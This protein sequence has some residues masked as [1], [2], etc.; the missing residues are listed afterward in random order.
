M[1]WSEVKYALNSSLGTEA[2][3]SLDKLIPYYI[4]YQSGINVQEF[5][6]PGSYTVNV[7]KWANSVKVTACGGG[8]GGGGAS[9]SNSSNGGGG[10]G[11]GAAI[12]EQLFNIPDDLITLNITVGKGGNGRRSG[13]YAAGENGTGTTIS[14]INLN[15]PGG[16]GSPARS[17]S[18][19]VGVGGAAGGTGGGAGGSSRVSGGAGITGA[20]GIATTGYSDGGGGGG[21][22]GAGGNGGVY[23]SRTADQKVP[24]QGFRGG[25]GGGG[26]A[27]ASDTSSGATGGDGY[28]K[29]EFLP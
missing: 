25:G 13:D 26:A 8:G 7:P 1:S 21:S 19:D 20:G 15:L 5:T 3:M 22:L 24:T 6:T 4:A 18:G 27:N 10:G 29:L 12:L 23:S 14:G 17:S 11:G 28:V 16:K 9:P 2:F